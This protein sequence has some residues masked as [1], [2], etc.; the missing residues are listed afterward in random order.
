MQ[1]SKDL[2]CSIVSKGAQVV[3]FRF[4]GFL[5][6]LYHTGSMGERLGIE[7][8]FYKFYR[9]RRDSEVFFGNN[10]FLG[11]TQHALKIQNGE[12]HLPRKDLLMHNNGSK[13]SHC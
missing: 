8:N 6:F 12:Y 2:L 3:R 1:R 5:G 7:I 13:I 10:A 9:F 11:H 4:L